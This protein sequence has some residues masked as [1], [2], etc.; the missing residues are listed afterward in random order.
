MGRPSW[1]PASQWSFLVQQAAAHNT[2]PEVFAAIGKW[3]TDWGT[4][5]AGRQGYILGVGV[6][7]NTTELTQFACLTAQVAWTAPRAGQVVDRNVTYAGF[8]NYART[9]QKPGNPVAWAQGV[10]SLYQQIGGPVGKAATQ[11]TAPAPSPAPKTGSGTGTAPTT[12]PGGTGSAPSGV[13][14]LVWAGIGAVALLIGG[15]TL[16]Q[17]L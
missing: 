10:W 17:A 11:P 15:V 16:T 2:Y 13:S 8:L 7:N 3:E 5:G 12:P 6:P 14:P 4:E 1:I 9:V